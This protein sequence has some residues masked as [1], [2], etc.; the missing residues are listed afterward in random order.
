MKHLIAISTIAT[1]LLTA[2]AST[3]AQS[4]PPPLP[5]LTAEQ[6]AIV[7]QRMDDYRRI[8]D[9]R[10]ARGDITADD[11]VRL[12]QWREWQ[13]AQGVAGVAAPPVAAGERAP[14]DYDSRPPVYYEDRPRD[15]YAVEPAP[16]YVPYYRYPTPYYWG[17]RPYYW[18]PTVCAGG[19]GRHFGGS[20]CF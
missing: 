12:M 11:A 1:G 13:I 17:A 15:Y 19:F 8:T 5:A 14:M 2:A 3:L 9:A 20:L 18:G 4:L 16:A 6:S 10:V 7:E